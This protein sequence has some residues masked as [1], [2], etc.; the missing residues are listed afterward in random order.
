[1]KKLFK[2][3]LRNDYAFKRVF[4]VE[5]NKDVL[6]DLLKCILDIQPEDIAGLELLDKELHKDLISDK[7]GVLDVKLRLKNNTII[8]IEIQNRWN[9]EFVQRTIFY[10]AKMYTENLKTSE[11]Y[12]KLPK[13]ITINI[14]GEGFDLNNLIHSEYNVIEKHIND[15]LS[16]EL[17]IHF[18][19]L[20][21]VKEQQESFEQD[22]K[23]KKL[24]NWLKFIKTDNPEVRKM[25]AESSEMMAKANETINIMEMSPKEKWLYENRMKYEHDKASWKHVGYQEGIEQGFADGSYQTKLETAKLMKQ[26]NCEIDFIMKM[27][28]LSKDEIERI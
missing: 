21:K 12:T 2:I 26:A 3:T 4:G 8:D 16:D 17:E 6:Q 23:K 18:L 7:T 22:E 19:N 20:A 25:L 13:C 9:S 5:E 27:T 15:R 28:S 24:Y 1:M 10:W 11:V 14:V